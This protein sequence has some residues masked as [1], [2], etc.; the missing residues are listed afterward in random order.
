[1]LFIMYS[2]MPECQS[3]LRKARE[4]GL[5]IRIQNDPEILNAGQIISS[6]VIC[7]Y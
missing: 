2:Q 1:M 6:I 4:L 5:K 3:L 7:P